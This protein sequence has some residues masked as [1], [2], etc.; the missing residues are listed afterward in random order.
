ML[1]L[2]VEYQRYI[3]DYVWGYGFQMNIEEGLNRV[4]DGMEKD[5]KC[6]KGHRTGL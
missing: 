4:G 2:R 1:F 6:C 5:Q 3:E